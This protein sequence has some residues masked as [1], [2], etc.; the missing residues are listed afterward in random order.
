[1]QVFWGLAYA[2]WKTYREYLNA[3]QKSFPA[4]DKTHF[5]SYWLLIHASWLHNSWARSAGCWL[6]K[7][8]REYLILNT[9]GSTKVCWDRDVH[10]SKKKSLLHRIGDGEAAAGRPWPTPAQWE[11]GADWSTRRLDAF[12][13][14]KRG[15]NWSQDRQN[16]CFFSQRGRCYK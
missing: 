14:C 11:A 12:Q 7:H 5:N 15:E 4:I 16:D 8:A 10:V 1:M 9:V 13:T 6:S 3:M 2:R